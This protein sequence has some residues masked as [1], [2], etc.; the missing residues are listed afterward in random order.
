MICIVCFTEF[1]AKDKEEICSKCDKLMKEWS[2]IILNSQQTNSG[3][4]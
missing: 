2:D 4:C 3:F 1:Q